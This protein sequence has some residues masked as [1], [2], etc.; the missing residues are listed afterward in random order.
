MDKY[1]GFDSIAKYYDRLAWLAFGK[2]LGKA[3][4]H[5]L[6]RVPPSS[7][8]LVM[9]GGTGW[10][11]KEFLMEKPTC[12][13]CYVEQSAEMIRLAR[14]ATNED[15]RIFFLIGN[16]DSITE[17]GEFDVVITFCF[18]DIFSDNKLNRVVEKIVV[19][20]KPGAQW[21][22]T[23]FV[24]TSKW[25]SVALFMMYQFF[26]VTTS[27]LNQKLPDWEGVLVKNDLIEVEQKLFFGNFIKSALYKFANQ[28]FILDAR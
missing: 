22:V 17:T 16:E 24:D 12:R 13:I 20:M 8:V 21:L 19:S 2:S 7:N 14:N 11:L 28:H 25:H 10:W 27:L 6:N 9:G 5:F 26:K 1:H 3:Q 15:S 18:L 4:V 23:D